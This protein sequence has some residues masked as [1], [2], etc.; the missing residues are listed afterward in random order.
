MAHG[1]TYSWHKRIASKKY[2]IKTFFT[3]HNTLYSKITYKRPPTELQSFIQ[4][5][6]NLD[7]DTLTK[8][9]E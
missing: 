8:Q 9:E 4:S 5:L 1:H 7:I 2:E 3:T 6:E